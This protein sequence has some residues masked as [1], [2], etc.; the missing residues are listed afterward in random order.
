MNKPLIFV[1]LFFISLISC[2][3][4]KT[5]VIYDTQ[6]YRAVVPNSKQ[7]SILKFGFKFL[8]TRYRYGGTSPKGFDCS[9]YTGYVFKEFGYKLPRSSRSQAKKLPTVKRKD[10]TP[11]DLVFF[12][13]RSHNGRVGH[14][15]IVTEVKPNGEFNFIHASTSD[16]VIVSSSQEPYWSSR[17]LRGGKVIKENERKNVVNRSRET[18]KD[19]ENEVVKTETEKPIEKNKTEIPQNNL[20]YPNQQYHIVKR[21]EE[22]TDIANLYD[23][24]VSTL[25]YLNNLKSN[26]LKKGQKIKLHNDDANGQSTFIENQIETEEEV[27][28]AAVQQTTDFQAVKHKVRRGETLSNIARKYGVSVKELKKRN[29]LSSNKLKKGQVLKIK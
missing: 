20:T 19:I 4:K 2:G 26:K 24:P 23:V 21:G 22:L 25:K 27:N 14:V 18:P 6:N 1:F 7:D 3:A 12:E 10:L 15:G 11:A 17:Y 8:N 13:G 5:A 9:G 16:G 28:N 29:N